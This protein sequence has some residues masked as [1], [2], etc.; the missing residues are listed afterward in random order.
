MKNI[1]TTLVSVLLVAGNLLAQ[2]N[3]DLPKS[4]TIKAVESRVGT[5]ETSLDL[6][7]VIDDKVPV[8]INPERFS[9][10]TVIYRLPKVIPGTYRV[11]DFGNFVD[12]FKVFNYK[13]EEMDFIKSD[14]N[15]WLIP[16]AYEL[17]KISYLIN[18]TLYKI[19]VYLLTHLT[20]KLKNK[21][22]IYSL[23]D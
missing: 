20:Q 15:S 18:D 8:S 14:T 19:C 16:N 12:D 13:G 6:T 21:C 5:I 1:L 23:E 4:A 9:Q 10:D 11:S 17:D 3:N 2:V 7:Q 22:K